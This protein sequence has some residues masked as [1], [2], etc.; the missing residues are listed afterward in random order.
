MCIN[1]RADVLTDGNYLY[2]VMDGK[3]TITGSTGLSDNSGGITIPSSLGGYPVISIG[4]SALSGCQMSGVSIP[5]G[6]MSIANLG[7]INCVKLASIVLPN[8]LVSIGVDAFKNCFPLNNVTIPNSVTTIGNSAFYQCTGLTTISLGKGLLSI[9]DGAFGNCGALNNITFPTFFT[10]LGDQSF[11]NCSALTGMCFRGNAP[12]LAGSH[13]FDGASNFTIYRLSNASGWPVVPSSWGSRPTA[14]WC[15]VSLLI[16]NHGTGSGWHPEGLTANVSADADPMW[17]EFTGWTG[18]IGL[19]SNTNARTTTLILPTGSAT[20]TASYKDSI[21]RLTGSY[22]RTY[23]ES[24]T[25]GAI[26]IDAATESPSETPAVK[27]G[28][29][30][31]IPD[32]G[33]VAFETVVSG[34]GSILFQWKVSSESNGDY[35][36]FKVDGSE[37][38]AISGTIASWVQVSNRV[39]Y[40][41]THTLRWE[42]AKNNSV[43]DITD[44]GWV[45]DIIWIGDIP[46]PTLAPHI[47]SIDTTNSLVTLAFLGERGIPYILQTNATLNISGWGNW[48]PSSPTYLGETNGLHKFNVIPPING[49]SEMFYRIKTQ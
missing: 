24:G 44:A 12:S 6:V 29:S 43:S 15:P 31:V 38:T 16:V 34:S 7:F 20:V 19:L 4:Y 18:D 26:T 21:A 45:D 2:T 40:I 9:G 30:G 27:L 28:G 13:T 46:S 10:N 32:T 8:S 1:L 36:K 23:S 11:Y 22:G 48:H 41:G 14:L 49:S 37:V 25:A 42:Y 17:K 33:F 3:A 35:L 47:M 5:E 39:D